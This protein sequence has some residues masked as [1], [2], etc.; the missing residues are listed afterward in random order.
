MKVLVV[1]D[2]EE[3]CL[4]L[5]AKLKNRGHEPNCA[6]HGVQAL[7]MLRSEPFDLIITDLLMPE[8]DGYQLTHDVKTDDK[9]KHI[10]VLIYTATYTDPKDETL[11]LNLGAN[12][13]I[14]KPAADDEFFGLI[15]EIMTKAH[16]GKLEQRTPTGEELDYLRSYSER[17]VHKLES[18]VEQLEIT[19]RKLS[20]LNA[21]LERRVEDATAELRQA[22][23]ELEAFAYSVS[24][25]L[26]SPLRTIE[27]YISMARQEEGDGRDQFLQRAAKLA[28]QG[29]ELISNLLE[30]SRL[31]TEHIEL[32][33]V[34]LQHAVTVA[35]E[36]FSEMERTNNDIKVQTLTSSVR[37]NEIYL[38]QVIQ[39]LV[40][41]AL[42]F[43]RPESRAH[44]TIS[45]EATGNVVRL[46]VSDQGIGIEPEYQEKIF[47]VFERLH[48]KATYPGTGVGLAIVQR[49]ISKMG[50]RVCV[51]SGFEGSTFWIELPKA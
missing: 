50:G 17:L 12:G 23:H 47:N 34:S 14:R 27:G 46:N 22:N 20:D 18:K 16:E 36:R 6:L 21:N 10:P 49:A 44:V 11:A 5:E 40:S 43:T 4:V 28:V 1:D 15:N 7:R 37:A 8:M 9:L 39:N 38:A 30:Y 19:R 29:Q 45:E 3:N 13:F 25:D 48:D 2:R 42:K 26:R 33:P 41:N 35:L 31:K 24:H 51:Q 32:G